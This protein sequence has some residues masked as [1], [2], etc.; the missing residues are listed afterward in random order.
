[1]IGNIIRE[2]TEASISASAHSEILGRK[3]SNNM[4]EVSL[5]KIEMINSKKIFDSGFSGMELVVKFLSDFFIF[6]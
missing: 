6:S 3:C 1:M 2:S 4:I 5:I